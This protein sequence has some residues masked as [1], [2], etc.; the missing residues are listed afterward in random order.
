M[1]VYTALNHKEVQN[2]I[3]TQISLVC[4]SPLGPLLTSHAEYNALSEGCGQQAQWGW[5]GAGIMELFSNH[6]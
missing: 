6:L 5:V 2:R 4:F 1:Q 3:V